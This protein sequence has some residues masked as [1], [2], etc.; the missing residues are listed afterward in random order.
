MPPIFTARPLTAEDLTAMKRADEVSLHLH[1]GGSFVRLYV[2]GHGDPV[3]YTATQQRL[4]ADDT[5]FSDRRARDLHVSASAMGYGKDDGST[6]WRWDSNNGW[7]DGERHDPPQ[8]FYSAYDND[9]WHTI[10]ASLRAGDTLH[11][12]WVADNNNGYSREAGLHVDEVRLRAVPER[13]TPR[14]LVRTWH[15]GW[16]V[17]QDNTARMVRRYGW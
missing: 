10:A 2:R 4:Y 6:G 15:L 1:K 7:M 16:S 14:T 9:V 8:C 11:L 5:N 17:C 3:V 12:E 13:R